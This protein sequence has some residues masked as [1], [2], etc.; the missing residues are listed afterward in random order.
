MGIFNFFKKEKTTNNTT[1]SNNN[2]TATNNN[3]I[4][5]CDNFKKDKYSKEQVIALFLESM[6]YRPNE[7]GKSNDD[8]PRYMYYDYCIMD[9]PQFHNELIANG[10]FIKTSFENIIK[11][12]KVGE[13]KE[14]LEEKKHNTKG[15]KKEDL[16][17][18][19]TE[20]LDDKEKEEF[21]SKNEMYELSSKGKDYIDKFKEFLEVVDMKKY[22]ISYS[23]YLEY[24]NK[25]QNDFQ[26]RDIVWNILNERIVYYISNKEFGLLR[27]NYSN[28]ARFMEEENKYENALFNY[29][30]VLY[31]D[32]N[33]IDTQKDIFKKLFSVEE[34]I[35]NIIKEPLA[36]G[37]ISKIKEYSNYHTEKIFDN[38]FECVPL[39]LKFISDDDF[40]AMINDIYNSSFFEEEK[41]VSKAI[42]KAK[43]TL[44]NM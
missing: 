9:I 42:S 7:L 24:K 2:I 6:S 28:M 41:Y 33:L 44:K 21:V 39:P 22:Q 37:I 20:T 18:I 3:S 32:I 1:S 17:K 15:L 23:M 12:Y 38:L 29:I 36:P 30:M 19:I 35:E 31:C 43:E 4:S 8:Y 34:M 16:I 13:L 10:Y 11:E 5:N 14:I 40:K 26:V 25:L 27:N